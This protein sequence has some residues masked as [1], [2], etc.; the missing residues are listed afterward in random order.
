MMSRGD[1]GE[2]EVGAGVGDFLVE[3]EAFTCL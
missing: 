1:G 3:N 2:G